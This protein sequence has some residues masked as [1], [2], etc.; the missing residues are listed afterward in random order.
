MDSGMNKI[1]QWAGAIIALIG[2]LIIWRGITKM[3]PVTGLF[4]G[5]MFTLGGLF[6]FLFG[7]FFICYPTISKRRSDKKSKMES[8]G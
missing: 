2:A 1:F 8:E 4:H 7:V 5:G 3:I 6:F